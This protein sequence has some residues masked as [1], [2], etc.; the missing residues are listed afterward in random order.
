[1]THNFFVIKPANYQNSYN[2]Y[3]LFFEGFGLPYNFLTF[4]L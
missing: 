4:L 1:M 3:Q 2:S